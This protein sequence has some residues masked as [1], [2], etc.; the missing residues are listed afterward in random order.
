MSRSKMPASYAREA[1]GTGLF[2]GVEEDRIASLLS[3]S[4]VTVEHY[5]AGTEIRSREMPVDALG[6][7][8]YGKAKVLKH[9]ASGQMP[10]SEL[11]QGDLFGAAALFCGE[12]AYVASIRAERSTWVLSIGEGALLSMM[13][14]E[15]RV[16][17]NYLRYLTGRI[18]FLSDRIDTFAEWDVGER[19][20]RAMR[21]GAKGCV[22]RPHTMKALAESLSVSRATLYRTM[23]S[24]EM[25]GYIRRSGKEIEIL[26]E[27]SV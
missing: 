6:I 4:G 10:M 25:K 9:G 11:H 23:E 16:L 20:L 14:A 21:Y 19:L 15:E 13:R 3:I 7:L 24:L 5:A 2:A 26:P 27:E 22:F 18:R 8:L 12:A 1:G 17:V